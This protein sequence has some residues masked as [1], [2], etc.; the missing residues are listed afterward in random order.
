MAELMRTPIDVCYTTWLD[1]IFHA[2]RALNL[3]NSSIDALRSDWFVLCHSVEHWILTMFTM[4]RFVTIAL[5]ECDR[6]IWSDQRSQL[7]VPECECAVFFFNVL[8]TIYICKC[9]VETVRCQ[10]PRVFMFSV[11][12]L[13][14]LV[15]I[16]NRTLYLTA[17][18]ILTYESFP[19][20]KITNAIK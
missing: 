8:L 19:A 7:S 15:S 6:M 18:P 12:L 10:A 14:A 3:F 13:S 4:R 16:K 20:D 11:F 9:S 1:V 2:Y 17:E 5:W